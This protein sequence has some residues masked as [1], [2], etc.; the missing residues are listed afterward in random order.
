M[1]YKQL[2]TLFF[3]ITFT[4]LTFTICEEVSH[5]NPELDLTPPNENIMIMN[6]KNVNTEIKKNKLVFV[7]FYDGLNKECQEF[8]PLLNTLSEKLSKEGIKFAMAN[9]LSNP[10]LTVEFDIMSF[11]TLK[12][13][14]GEEFAPYE[15]GINEHDITRFLL[16]NSYEIVKKLNSLEEIENFKKVSNIVVIFYGNNNNDSYRFYEEFARDY[17]FALF[18]QSEILADNA[19]KGDVIAY[20]TRGMKKFEGELEEDKLFNLVSV[21]S[22]PLVS[23][24]NDQISDVIFGK[25]RPGIFIIRSEAEKEKFNFVTKLAEKYDGKLIFVSSDI[26]SKLEKRLADLFEIET[27]KLPHVRI[28]AF[29]N[30]GDHR[31]YVNESECNEEG[32]TKF[33][34]D[35]NGDKLKPYF[36]SQAIPEKQEKNVYQLVGLEFD[37][38]VKESDKNVMVQFYADWDEASVKFQPIYDKLAGIY[39]DNQNIQ[40]TRIDA[41][42]NDIENMPVH[43]LPLLFMFKKGDKANPKSI[44]PKNLKELIG[45]IDEVLG[46]ETDVS[47]IEDVE[48]DFDIEAFMEED[49]EATESGYAEAEGE[50]EATESGD[51]EATESGDAEAEGEEEAMNITEEDLR[52]MFGGE[53]GGLNT[54]EV[55][56]GEG[57]EEGQEDQEAGEEEGQ[58]GDEEAGEEEGQEGDEEAGFDQGAIEGE[59]GEGEEGDE[60]AGLDQ[61]AREAH[62]EAG[63]DQAAGEAAKSEL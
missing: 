54:Q 30:D 2:L 32:I 24:F 18:G 47:K 17:E 62:E 25:N 27:K 8:L 57:Q 12:L 55:D 5:P 13:W 45:K 16:K 49:A 29:N 3:L 36:R 48:D 21:N 44:K 14:N 11:P 41:N 59:E 39:K 53:E 40:F 28:V 4:S 1:K 20:S 63:L 38:I 7:F 58:E 50:E 22:L 26:K 31:F 42:N 33:I 23:N 9:M 52:R 46:V 35:F 10:E 37:K 60:E 61:A 56:D 43:N 6:N 34:E 19:E 15:S 51:A